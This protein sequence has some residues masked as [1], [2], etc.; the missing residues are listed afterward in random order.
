MAIRLHNPKTRNILSARSEILNG[1]HTYNEDYKDQA[2]NQKSLKRRFRMLSNFLAFNLLL[3]ALYV[4]FAS[5]DEPEIMVYAKEVKDS[6]TH[7]AA[8][9]Y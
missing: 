5:K 3:F 4:N 1:I 6:L 8:V 9:R 2:I 7:T